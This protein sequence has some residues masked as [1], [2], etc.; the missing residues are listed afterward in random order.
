M[1]DILGYTRDMGLIM[2]RDKTWNLLKLI[3]GLDDVNMGDRYAL[4]IVL[5][6]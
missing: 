1:H 6:S 5:D 3:I 4:N 2:V